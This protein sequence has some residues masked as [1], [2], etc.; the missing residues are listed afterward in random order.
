MVEDKKFSDEELE[1]LKT[2]SDNAT[3]KIK[4]N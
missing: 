1:Q 2:H 4:H 3:D